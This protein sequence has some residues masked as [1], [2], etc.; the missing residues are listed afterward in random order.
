MSDAGNLSTKIRDTTLFIIHNDVFKQ[1]LCNLQTRIL[2]YGKHSNII[3]LYDSGGICIL[4]L[5]FVHAVVLD[6]KVT[7][8]RITEP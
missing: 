7:K 1:L 6:F 3:Y 5:T 8:E 4:H 2:C